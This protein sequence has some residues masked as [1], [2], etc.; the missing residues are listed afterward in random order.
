MTP[1]RL[2]L[3]TD[4]AAVYDD[5]RP[6]YL[7]QLA[8][9]MDDMWAAFADMAAPHALL[10][11]G[12][13]AGSCCIDEEGQ[14]LRF[15]VLPRFLPHA[16]G[17]LRLA[18]GELAAK[19]MI[20]TTLDP[21]YLA[22][23]LDLAAGIEPHTLLF[24]PVAEPEGPG[25]A[26]LTH[27][28]LDDHARIVDFQAAE[29]GAPR[30]FLEGYVRERIERQEMLLFEEGSQLVCVGELRRDPQQAGIAQLGLIV[31]GRERGRG[32]GTRMLSSLVTR[33]RAAGLSPHCSTE[34]TNLGARRAIE[35]AG[36]R[37]THRLLRVSFAL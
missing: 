30:S 1:G 19:R 28:A 11:E 12:A 37:A 35:R 26:D 29:V 15:F 14:L 32:V 16:T 23:A 5:H 17:L 21:G 6:A 13:V 18:L 22:P 4:A 34:V 36:F 27:A 9:P 25:L 10:V 3:R 31:R 8:A 20:V 24:A 7:A 33:S 2:S